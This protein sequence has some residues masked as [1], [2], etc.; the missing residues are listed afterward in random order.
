[1]AHSDNKH[2]RK[3]AEPGSLGRELVSNM[4]RMT[5]DRIG[6]TGIE[7][8]RYNRQFLDCG[9]SL[10][11]LRDE[12]WGDGDHAVVL[13]SGP[14]IAR[15]N[16]ASRLKAAN[17]NGPIITSE[18]G[19]WYCLRHGIRPDLIVTLDPHPTRVVRWLGDPNL[20]DNKLRED[21]YYSRQDMDN[22]FDD[23]WKA[24]REITRYLEEYGKGL[25]IALST[26][27]SKALVER[28]LEIGMKIYWWNPMYDDPSISDGI[29]QKLYEL[30]G[31]PC[32]NAGGNVG[33]AL[34]LMGHEVLGKNHVA[35]TGVD[36]SY[37]AD[38]AYRN[39]QYYYE[40]VDLVGEDRLDE[41]YMR[42]YNPYVKAWFYTDPAYMWYREVFLEMAREATW[43]TYNCT[44]GGILFGDNID[45]IPLD[46]FL[47]N[48][49]K[50]KQAETVR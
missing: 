26:S 4:E 40:A 3:Q 10:K 32:V 19:V 50:V 6:A 49:A 29:T 1:M 20:S 14:S 5:M 33:T 2:N 30:N 39:T 37:Y 12:N 38:T 28:V 8:A 45:F 42:I 11:E 44:E 35:L 15:R 13:V 21:D 41:M 31:L 25:R 18:S 43:K 22:A 36:F 48:V 27:A 24:N 34:W 46:D 47:T 17:Y 9:Q 23:Q 7:N 16:V